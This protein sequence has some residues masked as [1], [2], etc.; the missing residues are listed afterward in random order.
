M[1]KI[2]T[3]LIK[4]MRLPDYKAKFL[5]ELSAIGVLDEKK[6]MYA[7]IKIEFDNMKAKGK[8][9]RESIAEL[10]EKYPASE[11]VVRKAVYDTESIVVLN[12]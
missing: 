2:I 1:K 7:L 8:G 3:E 6:I 10:A 4:A 11:S 9:A 12:L 5:Y